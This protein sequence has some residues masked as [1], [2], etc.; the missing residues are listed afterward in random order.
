[1]LALEEHILLPG[2]QLGTKLYRMFGLE[3]ALTP[4]ISAVQTFCVSV[5]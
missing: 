4:V 2:R 1:M 3:I 5:V